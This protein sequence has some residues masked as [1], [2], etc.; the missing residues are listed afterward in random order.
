MQAENDWLANIKYFPGATIQILWYCY[1][2]TYLGQGSLKRNEKTWMSFT[3]PSGRPI[4]IIFIN[5]LPADAFI[6][7][8]QRFVSR[9]SNVQVIRTDS[10]TNFT[11]ASAELNN[12]FSGINHRR[13]QEF[14]LELGVHWNQWKRN[15]PTGDNKEGM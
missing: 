14:I 8:L 12:E 6:Q 15:P 11:G 1:A 5:L 9:K 13:I 2:W 3:Y 10:C 4:N 7:M